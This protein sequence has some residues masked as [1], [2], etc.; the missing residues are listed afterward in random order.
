MSLR[1]LFGGIVKVPYYVDSFTPLFTDIPFYTTY[2]DTGAQAMYLTSDGLSLYI[3]GSVGDK[4]YQY[5]LSTAWEPNTAVYVGASP[6][7]SS[8]EATATGLFFASDGT[9][10]YIVGYGSDKI[11]Q[12]NLSTAWDITT[13][14]YS[15]KSF[16]IDSTEKNCNTISFAS[17]GTKF[18]IAGITNASIFQYN[19]STAWDVSTAT[20]SNKSFNFTPVRASVN[21]VHF[22]KDGTTLYQLT[23]DAIY[24]YSLSIAWDVSTITYSNKTVLL[25]QTGSGFVFKEDGLRFYLL[26]GESTIY[27]YTLSVAWDISTLSIP[28]TGSN[29]KQFTLSELGVSSISLF[30][31]KFST[32]GTR[33]Y[34]VAPSKIYQYNLST[35]WDITTATYSSKSFSVFVQDQ[36]PFGLYFSAD[37]TKMYIMGNQYSTVFQYSLSTAWDVSTATYSN[38][39]LLISTNETACYSVALSSDGTK[40]YAMGIIHDTVY[41]YNLST[42]W[43]VSTATYSNLYKSVAS[44]DGVPQTVS[45]SQDGKFMYIVGYSTLSTVYQ[46]TLSTAWNVSTAVYLDKYLPNVKQYEKI[47]SFAFNNDGKKIYFAGTSQ[48]TIYQTSI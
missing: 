38:K 16:S 6:S 30:D 4:V 10:F 41:Q 14:T 28:S 20:Y 40:L 33:L 43:D 24:Q 47:T 21:E 36:A 45:F 8:Q 32:D 19:L 5:A 37:G 35:A 44:Q 48:D 26:T 3:V 27:K 29:W 31:F 1:N 2:A 23:N 11:Y 46:Y 18:Y 39:S 15:S 9:T 13:A 34:I 12:Y 17:D 7:I 25:H 42:A 22:S